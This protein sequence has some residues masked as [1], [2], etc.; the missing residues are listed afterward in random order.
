MTEFPVVDTDPG[1][2]CQ[3]LADHPDLMM[4]AFRF[5]NEGAEGMLHNHPHIQSTFVKSGRFRFSVDGIETEVGS[6][7][8]ASLSH[9]I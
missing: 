2:T 7:A 6:P 4:V 9:P 3:V 8:I 1:V 5:A